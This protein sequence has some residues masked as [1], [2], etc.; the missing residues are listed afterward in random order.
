MGNGSKPLDLIS[1]SKI[2][3]QGQNLKDM[4]CALFV[5]ANV[6]KAQGN[7]QIIGIK[8][9]IN[10]RS[11]KFLHHLKEYIF[12]IFN[13]TFKVLLQN[14]VWMKNQRLDITG[15]EE[16]RNLHERYM[17]QEYHELRFVLAKDWFDIF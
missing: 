8:Y 2:F 13:S 10:E 5:S 12:K 6:L 3:S 1:T 4:N 9:T 16:S 17:I 14:D 15:M 7:C 11:E